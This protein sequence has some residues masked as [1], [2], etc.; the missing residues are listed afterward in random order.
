MC[1]FNIFCCCCFSSLPLSSLPCLVYSE[2]VEW[3]R[4]GD[5]IEDDN[6]DVDDEEDNYK[7][8]AEEGVRVWKGREYEANDKD[9]NKGIDEIVLEDRSRYEDD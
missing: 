9:R 3:S 4:D 6:E 2:K 5:A 1:K 8:K 7:D